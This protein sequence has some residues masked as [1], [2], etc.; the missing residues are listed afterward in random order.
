LLGSTDG[1]HVETNGFRSMLAN[2]SESKPTW[3]TDP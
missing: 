2:R 1:S 3:T